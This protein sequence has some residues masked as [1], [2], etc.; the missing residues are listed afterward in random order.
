MSPAQTCGRGRLA[1]IGDRLHV[2]WSSPLL[3]RVLAGQT[4]WGRIVS[5]LRELLARG[6]GCSAKG[7]DQMVQRL[8]GLL[9]EAQ[10]HSKEQ[11]R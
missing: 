4:V 5:S 1:S 7:P 6:L 9:F 11:A 8:L 10:P 2:S 3:A